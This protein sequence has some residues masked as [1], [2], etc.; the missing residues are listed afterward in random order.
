MPPVSITEPTFDVTFQKI[1]SSTDNKDCLLHFVNSV[2]ESSNELKIADV[3]ILDPQIPNDV[4][5]TRPWLPDVLCRTK[6]GRFFV[7]EMHRLKTLA[8]HER[9]QLYAAV[10]L[11]HQNQVMT[12]S[13]VSDPGK[14]GSFLQPLTFVSIC[15]YFSVLPGTN[16]LSEY[17]MCN[18]ETRIVE[19]C[20]DQ[21]RFVYI[22]LPKFSLDNVD[23]LSSDLERWVYFLKWVGNK[24]ME[25]DIEKLA[26]GNDIF[27]KAY[28]I[29]D[30]SKWLWAE[31]SALEASIIQEMDWYAVIDGTKEKVAISLLKDGMDPKIVAK[32]TELPLHYIE[33]LKDFWGADLSAAQE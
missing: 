4:N 23:N 14:Y 24:D 18:V 2:L 33:K 29:C 3:E 20:L 26:A 12:K 19:P 15:Q 22:E 31:V 30:K 17:R 27:A 11:N 13:Y 8:F 1:F 32:V 9:I 21:L 16:W 5:L 25:S 10:A 7:I 28:K 6:C